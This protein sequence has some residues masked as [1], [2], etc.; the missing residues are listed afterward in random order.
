MKINGLAVALFIVLGMAWFFWPSKGPQQFV[1]S[2]P[3]QE[4]TKTVSV[5]DPKI[6]NMISRSFGEQKFEI[7]KQVQDPPS[8]VDAWKDLIQ[9]DTNR[10]GNMQG[11]VS[12]P[13]FVFGAQKEIEQFRK[14]FNYSS[15]CQ[16]PKDHPL[17]LASQK[18][19]QSCYSADDQN[20]D[21][22][23]ALVCME[24]LLKL[25]FETIEYLAK[26]QPLDQIQ[27]TG[28]IGAQIFSQIMKSEEKRDPERLVALSRRALELDPQNIL[29]AEYLVHGTFL[30]QSDNFQDFERAAEVLIKAEPDSPLAFEAQIEAARRRK[31]FSAIEK[32]VGEAK[33]RGLDSNLADYQ[34][35]WSSYTEGK[36]ELAENYL[37]EILS[38]NPNHFQAKSSL[39]MIRQS[40][41]LPEE[42]KASAPPFF[43]ELGVFQY[44]FTMDPTRISAGEVI[45]E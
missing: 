8:C 19:Q 45:S 24:S 11:G 29:A 33:E 44:S 14:S 43:G 37:Q 41:V 39:D 17:E 22:L 2:R 4:A 27:D 1:S 38:R 3:L 34:L 15:K 5:Q 26:D 28:L 18:V 31:E 23:K 10:W 21:P 13:T 40:K 32:M 25:R 16:L 6:R 30:S 9:S 7:K 20:P 35:A 42:V 36:E 12:E